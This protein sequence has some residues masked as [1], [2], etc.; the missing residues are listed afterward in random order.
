MY[1]S[2]ILAGYPLLCFTNLQA[3]RLLGTALFNILVFQLDILHH[4]L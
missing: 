2:A 1:N 3:T 4:K